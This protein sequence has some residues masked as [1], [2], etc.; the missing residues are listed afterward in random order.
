[1]LWWAILLIQVGFQIL[2]GLLNKPAKPKAETRPNFPVNDGSTPIPVVFGEALITGPFL[3]DW[4][5]YKY[6]A[7]KV[8]NWATF[9]LTS[10]TVGYRYFVSMLF[11]LCWD[12]D[13]YGES[14]L[15][16][17]HIDNRR[18]AAA[19]LPA[20]GANFFNQLDPGQIY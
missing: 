13:G 5:D 10:I 2:S 19:S 1:M 4:F 17:V 16:D 3:M 6:E 18:T 9:G 7:I 11:G 20:W 15:I 14:A 8:R 12:V